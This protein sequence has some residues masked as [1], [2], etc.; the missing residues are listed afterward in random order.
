MLYASLT[1]INRMAKAIS[2]MALTLL[3]VFSSAIRFKFGCDDENENTQITMFLIQHL[4]I[5][6]AKTNQYNGQQDN[7]ETERI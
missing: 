7:K 5:T 1:S 2:Q 3:N 6:N 4:Q